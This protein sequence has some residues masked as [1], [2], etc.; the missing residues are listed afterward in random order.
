[1][2]ALR[3]S[4]SLKGLPWITMLVIDFS[5]A[6]SRYGWIVL[7]LL[8]L[9][10]VATVFYVRSPE[11]RLQWDRFRLRLWIVGDLLREIEAARFSRTLSALLRGGVPLLDALGTVRGV[12]GNRLV[13]RAIAQVQ[14]RVKEGKGMVAPLTE[15]GVFPPL[16]LHMIAVGEETGK[17]EGM[18]A[19]VA[20]HYDQEVKRTT[21][22][23]TALLEPA[24]IL[25]MGLV[26]GLVV[27]SML[28]A[29]FSIH[30]LP[31]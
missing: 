24:L 23:L 11:G 20:A 27:I 8:L 15:S 12:M 22:R 9:L 6:L 28:L 17:L 29:I 5:Y 16:A 1:M 25:S 2:M 26:I 18:L 31:F 10:G 7:I 4:L 13:E 14:T 21:K 30:D 3:I 19:S